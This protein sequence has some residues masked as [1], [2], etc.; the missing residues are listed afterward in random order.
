MAFF[1]AIRYTKK[2]L[3]TL[4][5]IV[6]TGCLLVLGYQA[7]SWV[8]FATWPSIT[9]MDALST[10][11]NLDYFSIINSL[12]FDLAI[13]AA[14]V[15]FTTQLSLFL[16]WTGATLFGLALTTTVIFSK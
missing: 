6:W 13:K 14:Y 2:M 16:W 1:T 9:L 11:S 12:P 5:I 4:G 10:V 7:A 8:L 15:C 3:K